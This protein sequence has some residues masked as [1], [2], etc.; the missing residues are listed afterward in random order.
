MQRDLQ[1]IRRLLIE[2]ETLV[3]PNEYISFKWT[4]QDQQVVS[5][6]VNLLHEGGLIQ[7][8]ENKL[9]CFYEWNDVRL[10]WA[11]HELLELIRNEATWQAALQAVQ[12]DSDG[13]N[14]ELIK[15]QLLQRPTA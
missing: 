3:Y 6:H 14:L 7:A 11:G 1:L 4:D 12:Q 8:F 9:S 2:I 10:T 5:Y 15:Q 13:N